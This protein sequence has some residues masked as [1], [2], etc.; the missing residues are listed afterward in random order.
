MSKWVSKPNAVVDSRLCRWGIHSPGEWKKNI[1]PD[2]CDAI[3]LVVRR[4]YCVK[5]KAMQH[6]ELERHI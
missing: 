3:T 5:C 4:R 2:V 1:E 6:Q